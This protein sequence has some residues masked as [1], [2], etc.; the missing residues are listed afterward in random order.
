[1]SLPIKDYEHLEF[2]L[3]FINYLPPSV[4]IVNIENNTKLQTKY[5]CYV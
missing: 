2:P 4:D 3:S 5:V 1:M